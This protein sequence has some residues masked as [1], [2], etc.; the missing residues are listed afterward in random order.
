MQGPARV[1]ALTRRLGFFEPCKGSACTWLRG[2]ADLRP[3]SVVV[4]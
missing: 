3:S 1:H 4:H 2:S